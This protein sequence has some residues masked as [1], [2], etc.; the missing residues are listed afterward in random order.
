VR[1]C[2][3]GDRVAVYVLQSEVRNEKTLPWPLGPAPR[4]IIPGAHLAGAF[5][6]RLN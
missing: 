3:A 1:A 2:L 6:V 4:K 5:S